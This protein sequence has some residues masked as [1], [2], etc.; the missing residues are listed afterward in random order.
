M[1]VVKIDTG[2]AEAFK[3]NITEVQDMVEKYQELTLIPEDEDSYKI[4]RVALTSCI[5]VR[6]GI[7]KRRKELNSKAQNEIKARNTAAKQL[8]AIIDPA[9]THLSALVKGED[10]RIKAIEAEKEKRQ[11]EIIQGRVD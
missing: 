10:N 4:C 3:I 7:D 2:I 6:T 8:T 9:E 1:E 11:Q 5:R